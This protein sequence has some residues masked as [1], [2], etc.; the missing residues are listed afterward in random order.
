MNAIST[1]LVRTDYFDWPEALEGILQRETFQIAVVLFGT[2][3]QQAIRIE[4]AV[5]RIGTPKWQ[6][7]YRARIDR[8]IE[9]LKAKK[10]AIYCVGLP[11]MRSPSFARHADLVNRIVSESAAANQVKFI[12]TWEYFADD[13]GQYNAFGPDVTGRKRKLRD[14]DG[15]HLTRF[16]YRK[17]ALAV[18]QLIRQDLKQA[19]T[20]NSGIDE[21]LHVLPTLRPQQ[22]ANLEQTYFVATRAK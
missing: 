8:I 21:S 22:D 16:G 13:R 6:A 5:Y 17:L 14:P 12:E 19:K 9:Q 4:D 3:D 15:I 11:I 10:I 18:E 2:N 7:L 20:Q 1:G